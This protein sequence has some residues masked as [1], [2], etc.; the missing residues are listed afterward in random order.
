VGEDPGDPPEVPPLFVMSF[1]G[2][3]SLEPLFDLDGGDDDPGTVAERLRNAARAMAALHA[4]DPGT[5]G[6]G[7]EPVV[8][9]AE[10]VER[11][12][13]LLATVDPT[14]APGWE[15]V[16]AALRATEPPPAPAAV[17][18]G[19]FRLGNMLTVGAA[20]TA[21]IDW[22]IWTVGDPRVDLGWFLVNADP[23]TYGRAT[24]YAGLLPPPSELAASYG[25][26]PDLDWF[27]ALA[28]FKSTA[29][30]SLIVKHNRRRPE[31]DPDLE[32]MAVAL[33][34]LLNRAGESL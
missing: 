3:T 19:D 14:L 33:P 7:D 13:R 4:L 28:C 32:A 11:W 21:V 24:P 34:R 9:P 16:A 10:E 31:P 5:L 1:V 30:W 27:T 6:L 2:G 8:G 26:V 20:V 23:A 18:H 29:T 25:E 15:D 12:C 22:E 17:V